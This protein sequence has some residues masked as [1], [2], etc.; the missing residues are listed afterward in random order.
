MTAKEKLDELRERLNRNACDFDEIISD[1]LS[2]CDKL[3]QE[4]GGERDAGDKWVPTEPTWCWVW[5]SDPSDR[6]FRLVASYDDKHNFPYVATSEDG[7]CRQLWKHA[8]P[9]KPEEIPA[10]WKEMGK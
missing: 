9:C 8:E 1:L 10:W 3:I 2:L 7:S 5:D 4:A 6:C